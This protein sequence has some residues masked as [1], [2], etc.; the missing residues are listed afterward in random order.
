LLFYIPLKLVRFSKEFFNKAIGSA[1]RFPFMTLSAF[2][3][4]LCVIITNHFPSLFNLEGKTWTLLALEALVGV[5]LFFVFAIFCEKH[6]LDKGKRIGLALL[7][8]VILGFHYYALPNWAN[9]FDSTY[10]LRYGLMFLCTILVASFVIYYEEKNNESFWRY[11]ESLFVNALI[12]TGYSIFMF[13]GVAGALY[14]TQILFELQI[15]NEYY[16]DLFVLILVVFN[17]LFFA[18]RIPAKLEN[19]EEHKDVASGVRVFVQY[20]LLPILG[21]YF[22][23]LALY[24]GKIILENDLPKGWVCTPILIFSFL[25]ILAYFLAYP[26]RNDKEKGVIYFFCNYFFYFLMPFV[27]LLFTAIIH[28]VSAYGLTEWRYVVLIFGL[29]LLVVSIY[30]ILSKKDLLVILPT[31]LFLFLVIGSVGPWGMFQLS[32]ASQFARLKKMLTDND[33]MDNGVLN[34]EFLKTEG[35][36]ERTQSEISSIAKFLFYREE[37]DLIYPVL[38]EEQK[39]Q[40][41]LIMSGEN[42]VQHF[43]AFLENSLGL[44]L[45]NLLDQRYSFYGST[46]DVFGR[47]FAISSYENILRVELTQFESKFSN[48][49]NIQISTDSCALQINKGGEELFLNIKPYIDSLIKSRNEN[50]Y[51]LSSSAAENELIWRDSLS[52]H[53]IIFDHLTVSSITDKEPEILDAQFYLLY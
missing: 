21:I 26:F 42:K 25:G 27:A 35:L 9:D 47:G 48:Y 31:T 40:I 8:F 14:A 23:I 49:K 53:C 51:N 50:D 16:L 6:N 15:S 20:V 30:I 39:K 36:P 29:W 2:F 44:S 11:N 33:L 24:V 38:K 52:K 17:V 43:N 13:I 22:L 3:A 18:A 37:I 32:S 46:H 1:L 34:T 41:D 10:F 19:F 7:A 5:P 4:L 12:S 45:G 28:R